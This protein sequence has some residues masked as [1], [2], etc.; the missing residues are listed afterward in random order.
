LIFITDKRFT[1]ISGKQFVVASIDPRI[2][3]F[4]NT[5]TADRAMKVISA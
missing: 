3:P 1:T 4:S 5:Y 2:N